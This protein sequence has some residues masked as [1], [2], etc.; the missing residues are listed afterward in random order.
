[1][2]N[3]LRFKRDIH[4]NSFKEI[5]FCECCNSSSVTKNV[6][7]V[8]IFGY[9]YLCEDC[10]NTLEDE[11]SGPLD[12]YADETEEEFWDHENEDGPFGPRD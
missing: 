10:F 9:I 12:I 11:F 1:M 3:V 2:K 6:Y 5:I 8:K 4:K 7:K